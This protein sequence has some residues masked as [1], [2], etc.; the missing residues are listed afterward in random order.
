LY[1]ISRVAAAAYLAIAS[2]A[3]PVHGQAQ[4]AGPVSAVTD[5]A[6]SSGRVSGRRALLNT[7]APGQSAM[8]HAAVKSLAPVD[9]AIA[10][11]EQRGVAV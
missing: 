8:S 1:V 4:S 6:P 5:D 11:L 9:G 7:S 10:L 2:L 3:A